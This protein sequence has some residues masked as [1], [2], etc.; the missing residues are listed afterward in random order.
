MT[1]IDH[2]VQLVR[3]YIFGKK[4]V[5][6]GNINLIDGKDLEKL[7]YAYKFAFDYFMNKK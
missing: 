3:Q 4:N 7:D 6:I 5:D 1:E 2:K